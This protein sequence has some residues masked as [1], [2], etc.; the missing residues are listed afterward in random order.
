MIDQCQECQ[1]KP[2]VTIVMIAESKKLR[3]RAMCKDCAD[4][5]K[6]WGVVNELRSVTTVALEIPPQLL[7]RVKSDPSNAEL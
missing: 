1:K 2:A 3:A 6:P 4:Y 7:R 5:M